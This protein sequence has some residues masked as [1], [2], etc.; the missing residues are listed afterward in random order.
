[1][2]YLLDTKNKTTTN[3]NFQLSIFNYQLNKVAYDIKRTK[4][5]IETEASAL[6]LVSL[7]RQIKKLPE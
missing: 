6:I 7:I 5:N 3:H 1:M 2:R 4:D